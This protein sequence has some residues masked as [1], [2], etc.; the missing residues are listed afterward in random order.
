M[1]LNAIHGIALADRLG[2]PPHPN[3]RPRPQTLNPNPDSKS[4]KS[5]LTR[6]QAGVR[7]SQSDLSTA[8][9]RGLLWLL[10][11]EAIYPGATDESFVERLL[12]QYNQRGSQVSGTCE[13]CPPKLVRLVNETIFYVLD[14]R[15]SLSRSGFATSK[16]M[17]LIVF[18]NLAGSAFKL[19]DKVIYF[20]KIN[21]DYK[22][23]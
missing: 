22:I 3:P 18:L 1:Y 5:D 15:P 10:D 11:E 16:H 12:L 7:Y 13:A 6:L 20:I 21:D 2:L 23:N 4:Q 8:D 19:I 17:Y 9:R 14:K